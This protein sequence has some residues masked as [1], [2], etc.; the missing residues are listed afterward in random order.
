MLRCAHWKYMKKQ[1]KMHTLFVLTNETKAASKAPLT[2]LSVVILEGPASLALVSDLW[3]FNLERSSWICTNFS[4]RQSKEKRAIRHTKI[5]LQYHHR[6]CF[7]WKS[8][9]QSEENTMMLHAVSVMKMETT[10]E[11]YFLIFRQQISMAL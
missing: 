3:L 7:L 9:Y 10:V 6:V 5:N 8:Q 4:L 2:K 1:K 11:N